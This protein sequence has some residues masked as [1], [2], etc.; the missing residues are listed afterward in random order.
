MILIS[1]STI[2][3]FSARVTLQYLV[4]IFMMARLLIIISVD[5]FFDTKSE[6][7]WLAKQI[8]DSESLISCFTNTIVFAC[9]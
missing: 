7:G 8:K 9:L 4:L 3:D 1:F 2:L 6:D 5:I